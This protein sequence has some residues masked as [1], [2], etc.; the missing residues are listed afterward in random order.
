MDFERGDLRDICLTEGFDQSY[1]LALYTH[2]HNPIGMPFK[3]K[4]TVKHSLDQLSENHLN[5]MFK[6]LTQIF[7]RIKGRQSNNKIGLVNVEWCF[8]AL[9][10]LESKMR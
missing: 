7:V 3:S 5:E 4:L 9:I 1:T 10:K 6:Q 2:T 8:E